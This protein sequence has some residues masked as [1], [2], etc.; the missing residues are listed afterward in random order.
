MAEAEHHGFCGWDAGTLVLTA[1]YRRRAP[2]RERGRR[3]SAYALQRREQRRPQRQ[4]PSTRAQA[5]LEASPSSYEYKS[6][7][8]TKYLRLRYQA[9]KSSGDM[10]DVCDGPVS[11]SE[12]RFV[13]RVYPISHQ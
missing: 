5:S 8:W 10:S 9:A 6:E 1:I 2:A 11:R 12:T 4:A 13:A 7:S 3:S